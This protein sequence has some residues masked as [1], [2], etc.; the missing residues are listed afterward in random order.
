MKPKMQDFRI[1]GAHGEP[2]QTVRGPT[3]KGLGVHR[4]YSAWAVTH[5][6]SG[7]KLPFYYRL[8]REAVAFMVE[9]ADAIDFQRDGRK[10]ATK[11]AFDLV[12]ELNRKHNGHA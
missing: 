10:V 3:Y 4:K 11:E 9:A 5:L 8:R 2:V 12:C 7:H 1:C 6:I